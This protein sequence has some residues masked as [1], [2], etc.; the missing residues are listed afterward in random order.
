MFTKKCKLNKSIKYILNNISHYT[1]RQHLINK[2]NE[3]GCKCI[4]VSEE[5]TSLTCSNCGYMSS[6]YNNRI[7]TCEHCNN[8]VDPDI[9]DAKNILIKNIN[10]LKYKAIK[11]V[12]SKKLI[13]LFFKFMFNI[14]NK[15]QDFY[16]LWFHPTIRKSSLELSR[17]NH[18]YKWYFIFINSY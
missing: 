1:F 9:N 4:I 3:Y 2:S 18:K 13:N 16:F 5:Y 8:T 17:V 11:H 10:M 15:N 12:A 6:V 14:K 7:K